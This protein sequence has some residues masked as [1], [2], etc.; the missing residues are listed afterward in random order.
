MT[1]Q[2][3]YSTA[4]NQQNYTYSQYNYD[5]Y[6]EHLYFVKCNSCSVIHE[7]LPNKALTTSYSSLSIWFSQTAPLFN[8]DAVPAAFI[9]S[10]STVPFCPLCFHLLKYPIPASTPC[11]SSPL[12]PVCITELSQDDPRRRI[13]ELCGYM[14]KKVGV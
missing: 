13:A 4:G 9:P 5:W 12:S 11:V 3:D 2:S 10:M 6:A 7:R 14:T 8:I 1:I